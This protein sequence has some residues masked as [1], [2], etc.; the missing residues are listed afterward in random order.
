M[1]PG[2]FVHVNCTLN[3]LPGL[4]DL[5]LSSSSKIILFPFTQEERRAQRFQLPKY[6][7]C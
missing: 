3:P 5:F 2:K 1:V 7:S 4:P 6:I